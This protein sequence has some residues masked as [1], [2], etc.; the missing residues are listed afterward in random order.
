[1]DIAQFRLDFPEFSDT[2]KYTDAMCT[3][4]SENGERL[5]APKI[6]GGD[7]TL[8]I[9]LFTAHNLSLQAKDIFTS[10]VGGIPT[11]DAGAMTTKTQGEVTY[12]F[13]G[14]A[15]SLQNA[16]TYNQTIYGRQ[17]WQLRSVYTKGGIQ[18]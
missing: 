1:M 4:W 13:D 10:A 18:L 3:L 8:L 7:Y 11:G 9:E 6:F 16:G 14:A 5:N 12:Q 15:S 2:Q 17:Y